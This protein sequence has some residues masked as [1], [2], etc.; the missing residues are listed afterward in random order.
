MKHTVKRFIEMIL[1]RRLMWLIGKS[2]Y[3]HARRDVINEAS[4][5]GEEE[6]QRQL[7][8]EFSR[9]G[10]RLVAFDVGA[11][12]GDWTMFLLDHATA[13]LRQRMDVHSF[14]PVPPTFE[15]LS[16]RVGGHDHCQCAHLVPQAISDTPGQIEMF[17]SEGAAGTNS[18]HRDAFMSDQQRIQITATTLERYVSEA[19]L[20][21]VHFIKCDTEGHDLTVIRGAAGL[22]ARECIMALQFE[23][24]IRWVYSRTY[25]KDV[26]D[27]L[28]PTLYQIGKVTPKH[29]ELYPRWHP[30]LERYWEGNFIII[31]P[32]ALHCFRSVRGD[33]DGQFIYREGF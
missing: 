1:G 14:E 27:L 11:N 10:E 20:S 33:F 21:V 4:V 30:E 25:L 13:E 16:R 26:F 17:I 32:R 29:I 18:I 5:N 7:L 31:H 22:F 12:V 19:G 6:L 9:N 2:M 23:Y 24:N 3:L 8:H 28:E 15:V